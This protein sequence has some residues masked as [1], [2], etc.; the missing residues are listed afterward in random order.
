[1]I[2]TYD[3]EIVARLTLRNVQWYKKKT[4]GCAGFSRWWKL[5]MLL[6]YYRT[7]NGSRYS[8][9]DQVKFVEDSLQKIW[10][11]T[12][13]LSIDKAKAKDRLS[14]N[15]PQS[16]WS[17]CILRYDHVGLFKKKTWRRFAFSEWKDKFFSLIL[18][19][20]TFYF[21]WVEYLEYNINIREGSN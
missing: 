16:S 14:A 9:M 2:T 11:D 21:V 3:K 5:R 6:T 10:S 17:L 12:V 20:L 19:F 7:I 1:M 8:R 15:E 13:C 18:L 4:L